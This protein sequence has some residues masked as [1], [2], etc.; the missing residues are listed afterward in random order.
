MKFIIT[1]LCIY[2]VTSQFIEGVYENVIN[3]KIHYSFLYDD[4]KL[5]GFLWKDFA[6]PSSETIKKVMIFISTTKNSIGN[7]SG[8]FGT[9]TTVPPSFLMLDD[10]MNISFTTKKGSIT[11]KIDSTTQKIIRRDSEGE[12]KWGIW[13]IDCN[14][15]SI[16]KIVVFTDK[17][18]GGYYDDE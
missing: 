10:D 13:W 15:F 7:W 4:E 11:W 5:F 2:F 17:Y 6:I 9:S 18:K 8:A 16:D 3:E 1:L 14:D 12:L